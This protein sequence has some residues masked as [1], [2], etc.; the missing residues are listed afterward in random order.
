M[1]KSNYVL[2]A[3]KYMKRACLKCIAIALAALTVNSVAIAQYMWVDEKGVKQFSDRPPP[4][5][6][7]AGRILKQPG[8]AAHSVA[9]ANEKTERTDNS[10]SVSSTPAKDKAPMTVAEKNADFQ[11]RRA[12]QADKEKKAD[13]QAHAAAEK[14]K[15]CERAES[16]KRE[17][18][19]G[20]RV[21]R[22]DRNGE[23][24]HISD[25]QRATEMNDTRRLL[26]DCK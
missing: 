23:R 5:S 11:K 18:E 25:A 2:L 15:N 6:V 12:E 24:I 21:V 20:E 7:P 10:S 13:E 3:R 4:S 1:A 26:Q 16:Y 14:T 8:G 9:P 19:S 17:L 22:T